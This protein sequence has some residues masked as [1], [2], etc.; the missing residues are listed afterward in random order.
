MLH[1]WNREWKTHVQKE[2]VRWMLTLPSDFCEF[3]SL[4]SFRDAHFESHHDY[5][6]Y[7]ADFSV[8]GHPYSLVI[9][10]RFPNVLQWSISQ[11]GRYDSFQKHFRLNQTQYSFAIKLFKEFNLYKWIFDVSQLKGR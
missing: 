10:T 4:I 3:L 9:E 2:K 7:S 11:K 5:D 6:I 8:N 1:S